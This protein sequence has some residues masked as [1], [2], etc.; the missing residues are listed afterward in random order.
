MQTW[1]YVFYLVFSLFFIG[2]LY[3]L[4][5]ILTPFLIGTLLAYLINPLVNYL[6]RWHLSRLLSVIIVFSV[7]FF[8]IILLIL[9]FIPLIEQQINTL[10][11]MVPNAID[12]FQNTL[13]PTI[14]SYI[15]TQT[16]IDT[17]VLKTILVKQ[18]A[19]AG[20]VAGSFFS[21]VI[22]SGLVLV[23]LMINLL[24]VPV[25]TFYLLRDWKS[26]LKGIN[27]LIPRKIEP[28]FVQITKECDHVLSAFFRGQ[29]LVMLSIGIYYSIGLSLIGLKISIILGLTIGLISIVPYLGIIIG[30][31][32]ASIA[33]FLQ[34]NAFEP[35]AF[36]WLLFA[37]G[38]ILDSI[39][40]TPQLVGERIGLHPLVVIFAVLAGGSLFGFFGVLLALPVAAII[41]VWLRHLEQKYHSSH[42]YQ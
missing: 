29:L 16:Y 15:G 18:W 37:I 3:V 30:I 8:I 13:I 2:L 26:L 42:L 34:F 6:M 31:I 35:I 12:W 32:T 38:Q 25:V 1:N 27:S 4:A 24:I 33:A 7:T 5:P 14:A 36:V 40:I 28:A 23:T 21:T 41:M 10:I 20:T 39:F 9:L 22:H 17:N 11:D 19:Q